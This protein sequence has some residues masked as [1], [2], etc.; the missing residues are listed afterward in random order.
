MPANLPTIPPQGELDS[1][2]AESRNPA[3]EAL[4]LANPHGTTETTIGNSN[5]P[6][7]VLVPPT[8][9]RHLTD[10]LAMFVPCQAPGAYAETPG[11]RERRRPNIEGADV[12]HLDLSDTPPDAGDNI[13]PTCNP[14][15]A[16]NTSTGSPDL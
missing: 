5:H 10:R 6:E 7:A 1:M 2:D 16:S 9:S 3:V 13:S 11:E 15:R 12:E 14:Q 4:A 8:L